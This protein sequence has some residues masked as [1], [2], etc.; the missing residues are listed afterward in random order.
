MWRE[1]RDSV[2]RAHDDKRRNAAPPARLNRERKS[3]TDRW[4]ERKGQT[5]GREKEVRPSQQEKMA[6]V[7]PIVYLLY[8][9]PICSLM[10]SHSFRLHPGFG[11][12]EGR[13]GLL[14]DRLGKDST[15]VR[16][17]VAMLL[18]CLSS[19]SLFSLTL[20]FFFLPAFFRSLRLVSLSTGLS[21][22]LLRFLGLF[23][24]V[25]SAGLC[26]FQLLFFAL[27]P[28]LAPFSSFEF[29]LLST[30]AM[31]FSPLIVCL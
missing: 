16:T 3:E 4:R 25:G 9:F 5:L 11:A 8:V 19:L 1:D 28:V 17:V 29:P 10:A 26:D 31:F 2:Q 15:K 13:F 24:P 12:G 27:S 6:T 14:R 21:F 30:L 7:I 18:S 22:L 23:T 20:L